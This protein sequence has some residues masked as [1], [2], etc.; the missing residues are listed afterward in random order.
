MG[1]VLCGDAIPAISLD[2][3]PESVAS[4]WGCRKYVLVIPTPEENLGLPLPDLL[5]DTNAAIW[6]L[7]ASGRPLAD[8]VLTIL[9]TGPQK[10]A[11][12]KMAMSSSKMAASVFPLCSRF[13]HADSSRL[14]CWLYVGQ[15]VE[16]SHAIPGSV[17]RECMSPSDYH[18]NKFEAVYP[19]TLRMIETSVAV[20][21]MATM[22]ISRSRAFLIH[23]SEQLCEAAKQAPPKAA[24][25]PA[26][27][28]PWPADISTRPVMQAPVTAQA[29]PPALRFPCIPKPYAPPDVN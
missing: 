7:R 19:G 29:A 17:C 14:L 27:E 20:M 16:R 26:K 21:R 22:E 23:P 13:G 6:S 9:A 8:P 24:P 15:L 11:R 12:W 1:L 4:G 2:I 25:A 18:H 3:V 10:E 5:K 28:E